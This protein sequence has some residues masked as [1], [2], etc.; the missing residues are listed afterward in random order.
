[1]AI[2]RGFQIGREAAQR[3]YLLGLGFLLEALGDEVGA[4]ASADERGEA[5]SGEDA[6]A[7]DAAESIKGALDQG[8]ESVALEDVVGLDF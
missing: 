5:G 2:Q 7:A 1:M 8:D 3:I 6:G 4:V